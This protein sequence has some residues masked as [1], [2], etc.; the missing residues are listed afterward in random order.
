MCIQNNM[1]FLKYMAQRSTHNVDQVIW[2]RMH[3]SGLFGHRSY[4]IPVVPA[5]Q[6]M[7]IGPCT[8]R[9]GLRCREGE[10]CSIAQEGFP[11]E[12]IPNRCNIHHQPRYTLILVLKQVS[13]YVFSIDPD[14]Q[15]FLLCFYILS[16]AY[17][18]EREIFT[19]T[20]PEK[21]P[22]ATTPIAGLIIT[23]MW[24][25]FQVTPIISGIPCDSITAWRIVTWFLT[26]FQTKILP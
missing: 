25:F 7:C 16:K 12:D 13:K 18:M 14:S 23:C 20:L 10:R 15:I 9:P 22:V 2:Y 26:F 4:G 11:L 1:Y 3:D 19:T 24:L 21:V 6:H 8:L 5:W 17:E